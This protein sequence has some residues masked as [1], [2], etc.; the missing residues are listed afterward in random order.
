LFVKQENIGVPGIYNIFICGDQQAICSTEADCL[1][2]DGAE[3]G[4]DKG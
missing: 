2:A 1:Y 3:R 4:E